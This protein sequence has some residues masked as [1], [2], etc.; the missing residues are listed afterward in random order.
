M[1]HLYFPS[2][3]HSSGWFATVLLIKSLQ[4]LPS[5][6]E[7]RDSPSGEFS[8]T[9]FPPISFRK[10]NIGWNDM[11]LSVSN[12]ADAYLSI[13]QLPTLYRMFVQKIY[14][15]RNRYNAYNWEISLSS[16]TTLNIQYIPF[17]Y[18]N[19]TTSYPKTLRQWKIWKYFRQSKGLWFP[20]ATEHFQ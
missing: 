11:A 6:Y 20:V 18:I 17:Q 1:H 8:A 12:A 14:F 5:A 10:P 2:D 16:F 9:C 15:V 7:M 13:A 3:K 19:V 4:L